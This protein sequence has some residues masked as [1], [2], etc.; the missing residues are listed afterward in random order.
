[1]ATSEN[2][3]TAGEPDHALAAGLQFALATIRERTYHR[4]VSYFPRYR[5]SDGELDLLASTLQDADA[6]ANFPVQVKLGGAED[7]SDWLLAHGHVERGPEVVGG[8]VCADVYVTTDHVHCSEMRGDALDDAEC[9][10]T[11]RNNLPGVLAALEEL[12]Q[13]RLGQRP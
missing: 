13:W 10:V 2:K 12:L 9:Y 4:P 1:M 11:L 7:G 8:A 3:A 5:L 6:H